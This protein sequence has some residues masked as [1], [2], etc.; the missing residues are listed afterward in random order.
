MSTK[1]A[2][3]RP[4]SPP[5]RAG[6]VGCGSRDLEEVGRELNDQSIIVSDT[7]ARTPVCGQQIGE[8][9]CMYVCVCVY[10][11]M[12]VCVRVRKCMH[13]CTS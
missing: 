3:G 13:A 6:S 5:G 10:I 9:V 2:T 4:A 11:Y 7:H 1:R 12:C 8:T